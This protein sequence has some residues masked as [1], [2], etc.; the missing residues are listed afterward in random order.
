MNV[1]DSSKDPVHHYF[2]EAHSTTITLVAVLRQRGYKEM[3]E[4]VRKV[5]S[6]IDAI[7][8]DYTELILDPS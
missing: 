5:A 1:Y 6:T 7:H 4:E 8:H 2:N 3:A